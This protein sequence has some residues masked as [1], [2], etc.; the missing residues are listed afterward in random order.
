MPFFHQCIK[1]II[2]IAKLGGINTNRAL[3]FTEAL[4]AGRETK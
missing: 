3:N 2:D 1:T 4:W